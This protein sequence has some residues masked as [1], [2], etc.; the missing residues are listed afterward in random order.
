MDIAAAVNA[1]IASTFHWLEYLAC[2]IVS[3]YL[4][5]VLYIS[6][7]DQRHVVES[8]P[9]CSTFQDHTSETPMLVPA[10]HICFYLNRP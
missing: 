5:P 9:F 4:R 6:R 2:L 8:T 7:D 10:T 1:F 3:G